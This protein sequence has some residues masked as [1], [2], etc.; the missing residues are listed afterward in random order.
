ME[1]E[2]DVKLVEVEVEE[3]GEVVEEVHGVV[4]KWVEVVAMILKIN[5]INQINPI[6]TMNYC[7][8]CIAPMY[9]FV[10]V[11]QQF[12]IVIQSISPKNVV[13]D[14]MPTA[15][16]TLIGPPLNPKMNTSKRIWWNGER[17]RK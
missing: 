1:L 12:G 5:Q 15:N 6:S 7:I 8:R 2:E 16:S 11:L 14:G 4:E 17:K 3:D 13:C 9:R 10:T